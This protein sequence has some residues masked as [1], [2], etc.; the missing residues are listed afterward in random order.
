[1]LKRL[2]AYLRIIRIFVA[3]FQ[4]ICGCQRFRRRLP[5]GKIFFRNGQQNLIRKERI[6]GTYAPAEFFAVDHQ[7]QRTV[8][9]PFRKNGRISL[10]QMNV[11]MRISAG[12]TADAGRQD[13][14]RE[15]IAGADGQLPGLELILTIYKIFK[16][17]LDIH[18]FFRAA[19]IFTAAVRQPDR[20]STA[21][22][23]RRADAVLNLLD[24]GAQRGLRYIQILRGFGKSPFCVNSASI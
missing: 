4:D 1:M 23:E 7:V 22:E 11:N 20:G 2:Q 13:V 12:K 18:D 5:C 3:V 17:I 6:S 21:V 14:G 16:L 19:D 8:Q 10:R 24:G 15:K 9:E